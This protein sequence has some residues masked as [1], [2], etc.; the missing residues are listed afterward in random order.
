MMPPDRDGTWLDAGNARTALPGRRTGGCLDFV[1]GSVAA[2]FTVGFACYPFTWRC[3]EVFLNV[4]KTQ[5]SLEKEIRDAGIL[6]SFALQ[7]GASLDAL[8]AGVTHESDG[9]ASS[10]IGTALELVRAEIAHLAEPAPDGPTLSSAM[11]D[12]Q[13]AK[14]ADLKPRRTFAAKPPLASSAP[15]GEKVRHPTRFSRGEPL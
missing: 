4:S 12:A 15:T 14:T 8:V 1:W 13:A 5:G 7:H 9:G 11:R 2:T 10:I 6:A 3:A